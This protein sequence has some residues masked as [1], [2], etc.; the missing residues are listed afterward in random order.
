[1]RVI[2]VANRKGGT[3][4]TSI[5]IN[6]TAGLARRSQPQGRNVLLLDLDPQLNA[7]KTISGTT[8]YTNAES[9]ATALADD[10]LL[11]LLNLAR[12]SLVTLAQPAPE[13]WYSNL[14]YVPSRET[15]L[16]EVRRRLPAFGDR[17]EV[18]RRAMASL[19]EKFDFVV[20]DTGPSIDDLLITVLSVSD[21][22]LVPVEMDEHA[23]EGAL[24]VSE[25]VREIAAGGPCPKVLGYVAN[26]FSQRRV[27]D[28]N[29]LDALQQLFKGQVF[30][31]VI[32]NSVEVRYSQAVRSDIYRYNPDSPAATAMAQMVEE[33]LRRMGDKG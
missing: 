6:L 32:P 3:G 13:P 9:L 16:V 18:M 19:K 10:D 20:V 26:K 1:M 30:R 4:K 8:Q 11:H 12:P 5:A 14:F 7:L 17:L 29:A 21:Y 25:K 28:R 15:L 33:V 27:G 22:V 31:A 2:T 24:R 23:I